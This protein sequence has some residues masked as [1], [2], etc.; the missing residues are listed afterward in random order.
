MT[1]ILR[2]E[3]DSRRVAEADL[4]ERHQALLPAI[5]LGDD[6]RSQSRR[7]QVDVDELEAMSNE[8]EAARAELDQ[9]AR[10]LGI[11]SLGAPVPNPAHPYSSPGANLPMSRLVDGEVWKPSSRCTS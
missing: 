11:A 9:L 5:R 1:E 4:L 8:T 7:A 6:L 3:L 10:A 2:A